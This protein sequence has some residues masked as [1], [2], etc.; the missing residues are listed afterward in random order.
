MNAQLLVLLRNAL[1]EW[2]GDVSTTLTEIQYGNVLIWV[3]LYDERE[4]AGCPEYGVFR[5]WND[6][7]SPKGAPPVISGDATNCS[8]NEA[9]TAL[10]RVV[11]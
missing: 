1:R 2:V 5:A 3:V 8:V 7:H 9:F 11:Q 6:W 4:L 10:G